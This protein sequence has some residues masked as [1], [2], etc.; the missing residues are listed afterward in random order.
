MARQNAQTFSSVG[1]E[2]FMQNFDKNAAMSQA[3]LNALVSAVQMTSTVTAIGA[4]EAGVSESVNMMV[5]GSKAVVAGYT[6]SDVA[7]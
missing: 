2:V 4:F 5:E 6:V 3:D 1:R 7:F